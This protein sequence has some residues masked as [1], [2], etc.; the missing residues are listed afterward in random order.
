M[1]HLNHKDGKFY[2]GKRLESTTI[3]PRVN[4]KVLVLRAVTHGLESAITSLIDLTY[5]A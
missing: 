5:H 1:S 4:D 3:S 2:I